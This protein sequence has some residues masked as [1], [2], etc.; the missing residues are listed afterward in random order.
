MQPT[1]AYDTHPLHELYRWTEAGSWVAGGGETLG[2]V[3]L[4]TI[5]R[6]ETPDDRRALDSFYIESES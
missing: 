3:S 2:G 1:E 6:G 5:P 4:P